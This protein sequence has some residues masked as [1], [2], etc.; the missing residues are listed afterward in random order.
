MNQPDNPLWIT[1]RDSVVFDGYGKLKNLEPTEIGHCICTVNF[2]F[3]RPMKF[4]IFSFVGSLVFLV[5]GV[6]LKFLYQK[7]L[8]QERLNPDSNTQ[9]NTS[10]A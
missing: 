8:N 9:I 10:T 5:I 4:L 1:F 7:R 2:E 3:K 6:I